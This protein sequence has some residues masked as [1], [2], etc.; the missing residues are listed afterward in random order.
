MC[1]WVLLVQY[2]FVSHENDEK[3][4]NDR[5]DPNADGDDFNWKKNR[6]VN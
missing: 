2:H 6:Y 5:N 1:K 3:N 4:E